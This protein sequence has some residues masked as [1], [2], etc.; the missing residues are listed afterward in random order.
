MSGLIKTIFI[1]YFL[2]FINC[3]KDFS[4]IKLI[5]EK[6]PKDSLKFEGGLTHLGLPQK[7]I[8]EIRVYNNKLFICAGSSGLYK[9]NLDYAPINFVYLGLGDSTIQNTFRS[10]VKDVWVSQDEKK[11]ITT[12][13]AP[14][15]LY[16]TENGGKTWYAND[17]ALIYLYNGTI[18][19]YFVEQLVFFDSQRI[20]AIGERTYKTENFGQFWT[21]TTQYTGYIKITEATVHPISQTVWFCGEGGYFNPILRFSDD[22]GETW[23]SILL[24]NILGTDNR[25]E[26]VALNPE[27]PNVIYLG[28]IGI[29]IKSSNRGQTW[30]SVFTPPNHSVIENIE[31][32]A[33]EPDH[34]YAIDGFSLYESLDSGNEWIRVFDINDYLYTMIY[35][36]EKK[37]LFIGTSNGLYVYKP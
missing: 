8:N 31:V 36:S 25:I 17:S 16:R 5:Q 3:E 24:Y 35:Y 14:P 15:V 7:Y 22:M 28:A 34:L 11:L 18:V 23:N 37:C 30:D 29:I 19:H 21:P 2:F 27:N 26:D 6:P 4:A 32:V 33:N 12:F 20:L 13:S 10:G 9:L 1:I